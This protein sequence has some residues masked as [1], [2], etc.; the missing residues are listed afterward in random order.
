VQSSNPKV[1]GAS[2]GLKS[3]G[4]SFSE[5][6]NGI[7]GSDVVRNLTHRRAEFLAPRTCLRVGLPFPVVHALSLV[8][9]KLTQEQSVDG[10][11][12]LSRS[13]AGRRD[14]ARQHADS[15]AVP[16]R[17]LSLARFQKATLQ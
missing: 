5:R 17:G 8:T 9:Y 6:S 15:E 1:A 7:D 16:A 12:R 2:E 14:V 4:L 10:T 3:R 11:H 13:H